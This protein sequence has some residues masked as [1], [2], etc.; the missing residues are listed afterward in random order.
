MATVGEDADAQ[1]G[2]PDP[3]GAGAL[4]VQVGAYAAG[5]F[6]ERAAAL[7]LSAPQVKILRAV[8][9][10]PGLSQQALADL[11]GI[12]PSRVVGHVDD[13]EAK[14]LVERRRNPEDRRLH[15]LHL[16][17]A[18]AARM[19]DVDRMV[20]DHESALCSSLSSEE[21][22]VLAGLLTAI[23]IRPSGEQASGG[24]GTT[25]TA[26]DRGHATR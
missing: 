22:R 17:V 4:L 16:T 2:V 12:L 25:R 8:D 14:G 5:L 19:D 7:G 21:R 1:G 24:R 10:A 9:A 26:A 11:L 13:L 3:T 20:A 18:G 23:A 15:E 6:A